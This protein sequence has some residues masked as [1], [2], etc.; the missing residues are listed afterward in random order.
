MQVYNFE[1]KIFINIDDEKSILGINALAFSKL[2]IDLNCCFN[3]DELLSI[4]SQIHADKLRHYNSKVENKTI[5][6]LLDHVL[7]CTLGY[8][9]KE[10]L[11]NFEYRFELKIIWI[12][13]SSTEDKDTVQKYI[14]MGVKKVITKPL[15]ISKINKLMS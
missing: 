2:G 7:D 3:E 15:N 1:N 8:N 9:V 12:L 11:K 14:E 6:I 10:N 5:I 4:L 13:V